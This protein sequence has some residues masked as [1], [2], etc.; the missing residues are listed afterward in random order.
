MYFNPGPS[1]IVFLV[2]TMIHVYR[3]TVSITDVS[4]RFVKA[5]SHLER[6]FFGISLL[7][8]LMRM[9]L[10]TSTKPLLKRYDINNADIRVTVRFAEN[11][12]QA[13]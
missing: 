9:E 2:H 8:N 7:T 6:S 3:S 11:V 12:S 13:K 5:P 10:S 4:Y 1:I